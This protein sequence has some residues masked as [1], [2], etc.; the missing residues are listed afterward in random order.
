MCYD[1]TKMT[2]PC[3]QFDLKFSCMAEFANASIIHLSYTGSNLSK[4]AKYFYSVCVPFK[5][6]SVECFNP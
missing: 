1:F 4:D 6:E 2:F 3:E 5:F